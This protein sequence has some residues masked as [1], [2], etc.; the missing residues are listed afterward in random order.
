MV[1]KKKGY[2]D[3]QILN[4]WLGIAVVLPLLNSFKST[5]FELN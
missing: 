1:C 4:N 5:S 2:R 3:M